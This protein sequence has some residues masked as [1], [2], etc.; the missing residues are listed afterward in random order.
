MPQKN[1]GGFTLIELLI[2]VTIEAFVLT[3]LATALIVT[4]KGT[5]NVNESFVRTSD[6]RIAAHYVIGDA[7]NSSGPETGLGVSTCTDA[8]PPVAG[9]A[10]P[11]VEFTWTSTN[12]AGVGVHNVVDYILVSNAL[13]RRECVG[14]STVSVSDHAVAWSVGSV[15]A[16]C[17]PTANCS[18]NPT[19]ITVTVNET[20]DSNGQ[21]YTYSLTGAFRKLGGS[22]APHA[23]P[24]PIFLMGAGNCSSGA[25][26]PPTAHREAFASA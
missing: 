20:P 7:R 26:E 16:T 15:T 10:N 24:S 14:A 11:I 8:H 17:S 5:T 13:L 23:A 21:V 4:F 6:A 2:T 9:A 22:G 3:A 1:E 25:T 19:T 12:S 18:G